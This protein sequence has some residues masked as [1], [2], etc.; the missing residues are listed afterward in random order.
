MYKKLIFKPNSKKK[1]KNIQIVNLFVLFDIYIV[2]TCISYLQRNCIFCNL[3]GNADVGMYL[4][5]V[6]ATVKNC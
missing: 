1:S 4:M 3:E 5:K 6:T 2:L